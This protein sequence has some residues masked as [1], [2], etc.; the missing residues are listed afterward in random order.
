MVDE[1]EDYH[2]CLDLGPGEAERSRGM[3]CSV[4]PRLRFCAIV[5]QIFHIRLNNGIIYQH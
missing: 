4:L 3:P 5:S 2:D 1:G